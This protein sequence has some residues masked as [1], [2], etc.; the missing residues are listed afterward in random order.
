MNNQEFK[1]WP[2]IVNISSDAPTFYS[3]NVKINRCRGGWN[4]I[5][6][7]YTKVC[8]PDVVKKY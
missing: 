6:G 2:E 1:I 3:Y 4:N 8:V 7:P 5:N